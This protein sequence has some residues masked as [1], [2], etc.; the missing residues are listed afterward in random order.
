MAAADKNDE[1][2]EQLEE[3]LE[4]CWAASEGFYLAYQPQVDIPTRSVIGFEALLRWRHPVRGN[5][6]PAIF[7]PLA[8]KSGLVHDI[9][10]WVLEQACDEAATWPEQMSL[11]INVSATQLEN[12]ALPSIV[13]AILQQSGLS[14]SRLELEITETAFLPAGTNRLSVLHEI[15]STGVRIAMDDLDV[16]YASFAYLLQFPFDKIKLDS[17]FINGIAKDRLQNKTA[18]EIVKAIVQLCHNLNITFLAEGVETEEQLAFLNDCGCA[19][20]QGYLCGRPLPATSV[21]G[22]LRSVANIMSRLDRS[23]EKTETKKVA[24]ATLPFS[25]IA[26]SVNDILIVTTPDLD[27]PGPI[28]LY[29]NPAFTRLTGYSAA[30]AIGSTPRILQGPGTNIATRAIIRTGLKAGQPV[31]E[32]I[33]NFAKSGAPYWLDL[34]IVPLRD[35]NGTITHFAAVERD[36]TMDKRRLDEL[37]HLADRDTLTGIPNRR[38]FFR[39]AASNVENAAA[40][41]KWAIGPKRPCLAFIDVDHFKLVNDELGHVVGDAVLC[42]VAEC[43]TEN[44]RRLDML[45]RIGGEEFAVCMP[46]VT[47]QEATALAERLRRAVAGTQMATPKGPVTIT[48]SIGVACLKNGESITE[49]TDR[50][51]EAMYAAKRAGRNRVRAHASKP[52]EPSDRLYRSEQ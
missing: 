10:K 33:L 15:Q 34:H 38:A 14:P 41:A 11:A 2:D 22:V 17:V 44:V 18:R 13:A 43:L 24:F 6:S 19:Q 35:A 7:I 1:L 52:R 50:A 8:E 48:V 37:E 39:A 21:S 42:G 49:L 12:L 46:A 47:L 25:Q 28:I 40:D 4:K 16:G 27:P 23:D 30:E 3:E 51:D 20:V 31:H 45:G 32:K 26:D 9:C 36:V 5:V 29:V